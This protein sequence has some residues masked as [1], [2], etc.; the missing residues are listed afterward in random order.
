MGHIDGTNAMALAF[1]NSGGV[2]Q[3]VGYTVT[4]WYGYA[5]WGCLDYFVEQ[6]GRYTLA[7]A[8][9]ANQTALINRLQTV[10]PRPGL[11]GTR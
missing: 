4:T 7:E 11:G 10:F 3:M 9:R 2:N 6:P 8:F 1:L 5:G